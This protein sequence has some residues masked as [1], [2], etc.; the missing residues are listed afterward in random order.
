MPTTN[1]NEPTDIL[2]LI[3]HLDA[4]TYRFKAVMEAGLMHI[5]HME[6]AFQSRPET[7]LRMHYLS[8]KV[9]EEF[10]EVIARV[11]ERLRG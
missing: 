10:E 8:D 7:S 2:D 1:P 11:K 9:E 5:E 4:V 6:G 3:D